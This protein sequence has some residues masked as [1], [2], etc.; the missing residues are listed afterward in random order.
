MASWRDWRQVW[1]EAVAPLMPTEGLHALKEALES[2]DSTLLQGATTSPPP[3]SCCQEWPVEAACPIGYCG[4]RGLGLET[5]AEVE[6]FFA[7][8]CF[9]ADYTMGEPAGV[10]FFLN[11]ADETPREEMRKQLLDEVVRE[12][13]GREVGREVLAS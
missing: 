5:V 11:W 4:W 3:L 12:L 13:W 2:N 8:T 1:R 10:R 6:E 9:E 7:R